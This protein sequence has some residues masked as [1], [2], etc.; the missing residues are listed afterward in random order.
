M[1]SNEVGLTD[2]VI[3]TG[4][5][6][7]ALRG[8]MKRG[9]EAGRASQPAGVSQTRATRR[10][11]PLDQVMVRFQPEASGETIAAVFAKLGVRVLHHIKSIDVYVLRAQ[12]GQA[13]Q[14]VK[15]LQARQDV[16]YAE[17]DGGVDI[18]LTP[19]DPVYN[20]PTR[21]YAPQF[22]N[23]LLPTPTPTPT[24]FPTPNDPD[25]SDVTRVYAPQFINA[26]AAWPYTTGVTSVI[27]AVVDTGLSATHPEFTGRIVSG[28]NYVN[29]TA[30][31]ADDHGHGTH[32][33]GIVAA[34]MN[35]L[36]GTTGIAPGVKIMPLKAFDNTGYGTWSNIA[37]SIDFAVANGAKVINLSLGNTG[38]ST[39]VQD[40]VRNATNANRLVVAAA[41]NNGNTTPFYPACY[42]EAMSIAATDEYDEWWT[43]SNYHNC[44]DVSA[45]GS[46]IWSTLW[47]AGDPNTYN[48]RSGTSQAAPHVAGLAAL[49][50]SNRP[51]L[52][53]ADVRALIEQTAVDKGT[54]G[55][56][57]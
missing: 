38:G 54:V 21:V 35:N 2:T 39:A 31:T 25:Y 1:N 9:V 29:N 57:A 55:W 24:P 6:A 3:Q 37:L 27:V 4:I 43:L 10:A 48:F 5:S 13:G 53:V 17:Q 32:V 8:S 45:P 28:F 14:V 42:A 49:I 15:A 40:A 50:W 19:T 20:D 22:I 30:N 34:A 33:S 12:P 44:N 36:Q 46:T 47:T 23:I 18:Q 52:S 16:R 41:G 56:D 11:G 7:P 26:L 51:E